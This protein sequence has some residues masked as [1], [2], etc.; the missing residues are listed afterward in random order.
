MM[1]FK[2]MISTCF[3]RGIQQSLVDSPHK[4]PIMLN[5]D[6]FFFCCWHQEAVGQTAM[7]LGHHW[8]CRWCNKNPI[9]DYHRK[10]S[11]LNNSSTLMVRAKS[12]SNLRVRNLNI[13]NMRYLSDFKFHV[14]NLSVKWLS[15]LWF[16][17]CNV[18]WEILSDY[19]LQDLGTWEMFPS[20][21]MS[22]TCHWNTFC[23]TG[24]LWGESTILVDSPHKGPGMHT[25][26]LFF[27]VCRTRC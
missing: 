14:T 4:G 2:E 24:P 5:L 11:H 17:S 25:T 21:E 7:L 20:V 26:D 15:E 1:A 3:V 8:A 27:A 22:S 10:I 6:V 16:S 19:I 23:I 13:W 9:T 12:H 18:G